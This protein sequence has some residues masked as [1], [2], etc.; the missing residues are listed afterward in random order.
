MSLCGLFAPLQLLAQDTPVEVAEANSDDEVIMMNPFQVDTSGDRGYYAANSISGSR[1]NIAIQDIPMPIEVITSEFIEDTGSQDLRESLRYSSGVVLESQN[2]AG[3]DLDGVPGGVHNG[4]GATSNLTSTSFK[5]RGF[6]T[7]TSLRAGYRRQHGS[8]AVNIDRVEVVRGPAAL[9]YGVG[10]F[11][12]VINYLPKR[13]LGEQFT[14]LNFSYGRSNTIRTTFD[15]TDTVLDGRFGYRLTGAFEDGNHWT[16]V[17]NH[18]KRFISPVLV[19]EPFDGTKMTLDVE[20]GRERTNGIGFQRMRARG[21]GIAIGDIENQQGRLQKGG[22]V[23]FEEIDERTFRLSGPDTFIETDAYNIQFEFEQN[24]FEGVDLKIGHNHAVAKVDKRDIINNAYMAGIGPANLQSTINVTPFQ[25]LN[26]DPIYDAELIGNEVLN[27]AIL[28][29]MW[30]DQFIDRKRD[31][32]RFELNLYRSFFQNSSWL[33]QSHSV[34]LGV[35]RLISIK[36][37][38]EFASGG[39]DIGSF[40][41]KD[42]N[43]FSLIRFGEGIKDNGTADGVSAFDPLLPTGSELNESSNQA[44]YMV[45][46]GSFWDDRITTIIGL[47]KDRND[48]FTEDVVYSGGVVSGGDTF[49]PEPQTDSTKQYGLNIEVIDGVSLFALKS[50]G[51]E[52]NFDGTRGFNGEALGSTIA[53]SKEYGIK[54]NLLGGRIAATFSRYNLNA[55]GASTRGD[56]W[57]APAPGKN[58][59]DPTKPT[60]YEITDLIGFDAAVGGAAHS[61]LIDEFN[62]ADAA[63]NIIRE[64]GRT[65]IEVLDANGNDTVGAAYLDGFFS[66]MSQPTNF[67]GGW[68][69][70]T[71]AATSG[72][73]NNAAMDWAADN[74]PGSPFLKPTTEEESNGYEVQVLFTITEDWQMYTSYAKTNRFLVSEGQFA[75]YPFP[76]DRWAIW[77]F[78][79]GNWGLQGAGINQAYEDP[80][81]TSTWT[82]GPSSKNGLS[83]DDTP[84]HDVAFWTSYKFS[85]GFMEGLK[86]GFGGDFESKREYLSGFTV[87]GDAIKD[88]SG[89]LI[90][91]F[92]ASKLQFNAMVRYDYKVGDNMDAYV[93]VNVD[94]LTNDKK[95]YGY[96]YEEGASWR[97]QLGTTF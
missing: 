90:Q 28:L 29:Y 31:E 57:W 5:I 94:N 54:L 35:S 62:A 38:Q 58:R 34:L 20:Y 44:L 43:D 47:R 52:P 33:N 84:K 85:E 9:L 68:L 55:I 46:Q 59:Y 3:A 96:V 78:P 75:R 17:Q 13:P 79:D 23:E 80:T 15:T 41:Y 39:G 32:T 72:P 65:Y 19:Y 89:N 77:Y 97:I 53:R 8:D 86:L 22:F 26:G 76:Q 30:E 56:L 70:N 93:Q 91:A 64:G 67:W 73:G 45:W 87:G 12:G 50:Q 18:N 40:L 11:G 95:L 14:H 82:G 16:D 2:D 36:D 27:D 42:P 24:L 61:T 71:S 81:D 21:T 49:N 66:W 60:V 25:Q 83:L 48:T 92:T 88:D 6:V 7:D 10:N 74:P 63:G 69:Y 37:Q 4:A 51:L 1:V